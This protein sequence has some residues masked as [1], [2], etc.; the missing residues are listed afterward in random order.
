M[1]GVDPVLAQVA[2]GSFRSDR[3]AHLRERE[4]FLGTK[5]WLLGNCVLVPRYLVPVL[6]A[7]QL[8]TGC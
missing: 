3:I 2:S 8:G 4:R 6:V 7:R 1:F 5:C